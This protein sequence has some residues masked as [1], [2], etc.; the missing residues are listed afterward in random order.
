MHGM[1]DVLDGRSRSH[2]HGITEVWCEPSLLGINSVKGEVSVEGKLVMKYKA[3]PLTLP[4][5]AHPRSC[6]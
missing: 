5:E 3:I 6:P 4:A 1:T 2:T